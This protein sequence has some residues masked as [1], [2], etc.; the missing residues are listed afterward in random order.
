[1]EQQEIL[2]VE[3]VAA[4][5]RICLGKAYQLVHSSNFPARKIDKRILVRKS[6]LDKWLDQQTVS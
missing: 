6:E 5:L 3:E 1:M 2:T 4:Y